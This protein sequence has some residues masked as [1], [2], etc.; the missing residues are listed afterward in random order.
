MEAAADKA[1]RAVAVV[2]SVMRNHSGPQAAKRGLL[3]GVADSVIRYASPI[4]AKAT[5]LQW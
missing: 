3:A 5:N 1:L 2:T 4:W